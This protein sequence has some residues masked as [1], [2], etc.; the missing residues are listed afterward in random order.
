ML[1][2]SGKL[3]TVHVCFSSDVTTKAA[4]LAKSMETLLQSGQLPQNVQT[5]VESMQQVVG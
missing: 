2:M 4:V 1:A 5:L 3:F